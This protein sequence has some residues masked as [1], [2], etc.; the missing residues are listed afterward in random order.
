MNILSRL[1]VNAQL[2]I[3]AMG[4]KRRQALNLIS[5][6]QVVVA[7]HLTLVVGYPGAQEQNHWRKELRNYFQDILDYQD[8]SN[9]DIPRS[10]L[11]EILYEE[12]FSTPNDI[13]IQ[14]RRAAR[15]FQDHPSNPSLDAQAVE[16]TDFKS[17]ILKLL[18]DPRYLQDNPSLFQ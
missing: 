5:S 4:R 18:D 11:L 15:H 17:L 7:D 8:S 6:L 12:T 2:R 10:L 13:R 16:S 1:V 3:V 14:T 9:V